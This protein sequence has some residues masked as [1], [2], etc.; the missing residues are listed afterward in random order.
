MKEITIRLTKEEARLSEL[1]AK[2]TNQTLVN[3]FKSSL[4]KEIESYVDQQ[5]IEKRTDNSTLIRV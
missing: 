2:T 3:A 4:E 1:Y 5:V